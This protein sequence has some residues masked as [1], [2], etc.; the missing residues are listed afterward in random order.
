MRTRFKVLAAL[1]GGLSALMVLTAALTLLPGRLPLPSSG[2]LTGIAFAALFPLGAWTVVEGIRTGT[3]RRHQ[4]LAFRCLPGRVRLVVGAL[5]VAAAVNA[6]AAATTESSRQT[7]DVREGRYYAFETSPGR[8]GTVEVSR[9]EYAELME[10]DQRGSLAVPG[11][12]LAVLTALALVS[13][14]MARPAPLPR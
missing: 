14:E 2:I 5:V 1:T 4:W 13:G 8:R 10:T 3:E 9:Q 11:A 6:Y 12:I 7:L